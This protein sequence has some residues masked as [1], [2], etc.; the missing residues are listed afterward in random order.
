[1][2]ICMS[3]GHSCTAFTAHMY[4]KLIFINIRILW[5]RA[6]ISWRLYWLAQQ[7]EKQRSRAPRYCINSFGERRK[8]KLFRPES[9]QRKLSC[10]AWFILWQ[11]IVFWMKGNC[12]NLRYQL[13]ILFLLL[14]LNCKEV[15]NFNNKTLLSTPT[16]GHTPSTCIDGI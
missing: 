6:Q 14:Q 5:R 3:K 12:K 1:M 8:S 11:S 9:S 2:Q 4:L 15:A 7:E 10:S 16:H 13:G